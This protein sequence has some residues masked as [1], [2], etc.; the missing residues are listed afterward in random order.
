MGHSSKFC[1][2]PR[3][4]NQ[5]ENSFSGAVVL[6][7]ECSNTS[8]H[9]IYYDCNAGELSCLENVSYSM[10]Q[11]DRTLADHECSA[12]I[13]PI[14]CTRMQGGKIIAPIESEDNTVEILVDSGAGRH[15]LRSKALN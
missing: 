12:V 15:C 1:Q 14:V 5:E 7:I 9:H 2:K 3:K 6:S 11:E 10:S 4:D 8:D 13:S